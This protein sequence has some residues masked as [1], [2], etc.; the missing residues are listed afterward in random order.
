MGK[1]GGENPKTPGE[2]NS[3]SSAFIAAQI[4]VVVVVIIVGLLSVVY[5]E[6]I[7]SFLQ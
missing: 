5:W 7:A 4:C 2:L 3:K 6:E 1:V